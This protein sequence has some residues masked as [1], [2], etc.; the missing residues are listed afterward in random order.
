MSALQ[1]AQS[2][3]LKLVLDV[4]PDLLDWFRDAM[5]KALDRMENLD[6]ELALYQFAY[7]TRVWKF[8]VPVSFTFRVKH[9]R[10][11]AHG[12]LGERPS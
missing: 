3:E 1:N 6:G 2:K 7:K 8:T 4:F 9:L 11:V 12:L 5:W 10:Y